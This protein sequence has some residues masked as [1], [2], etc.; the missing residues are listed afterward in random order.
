MLGFGSFFAYYMGVSAITGIISSCFVLTMIATP[1]FAKLNMRHL[2]IILNAYIV[3]LDLYIATVTLIDSLVFH[4][5]PIPRRL[6]THQFL[7]Q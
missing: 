7:H 1:A 6:W 4:L 3:S 5:D 2:V